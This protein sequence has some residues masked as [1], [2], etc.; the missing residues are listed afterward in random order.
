MVM[1]PARFAAIVLLPSPFVAL[2]T[3]TVCRDFSSAMKSLPGL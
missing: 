1:A 3:R 2:V